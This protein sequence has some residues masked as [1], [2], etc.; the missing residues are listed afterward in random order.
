MAN[1]LAW[2]L[3]TAQKMGAKAAG[4]G[5][6]VWKTLGGKATKETAEAVGKETGEKLAAI[7]AK[8]AA[9]REVADTY[10]KTV[11]EARHGSGEAAQEALEKG[12]QGKDGTISFKGD[13]GV[14]YKRERNP[15]W[16]EGDARKSEHNPNGRNQWLYTADGQAINGQK[17]GQAQASFKQHGGVFGAADEEV[18]N[19]IMGTLKE[20]WDGIPGWAKTTGAITAGGIAGAT[21]FGGD[22]DNYDD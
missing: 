15:N 12:T 19:G 22:D 21:L 10:N 3:E 13:D 9:R 17:F 11:R 16:K 7:D 4:K 14:T 1:P 18:A 20:T 2:G 5:K 8:Q 6:M